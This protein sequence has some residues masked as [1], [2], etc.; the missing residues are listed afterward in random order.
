MTRTTIVCGKPWPMPLD[1][2]KALDNILVFGLLHGFVGR[3]RP[4]EWVVRIGRS[5]GHQT[6]SETP[7]DF[8]PTAPE[9]RHNCGPGILS[10]I[11][12]R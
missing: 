9:T 7:H 6:D 1:G 8:S 5:V 3:T 10:A 11:T 4:P 2:V 12:D